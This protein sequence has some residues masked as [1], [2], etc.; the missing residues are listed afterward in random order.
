MKHT[1]LILSLFGI[2]FLSSTDTIAQL[3]TLG[4][5]IARAKN[6]STSA[7]I[8]TSLKENRNYLYESYKATLKPQLSLSGNIAD[9]S[10]DFFGVRQPDGSLIFLPRK[11]NYSNIGLSLSQQIGLTGGLLAVNSNLTRFDD[12]S[13]KE[14]QYSGNPFT[15]SLNQPLFAFNS[16]KWDRKIE[17]LKLEEAEKEYVRKVEILSLTVTKLYFDVLDAQG[18][19]TLAKKNLQNQKEILEIENQKIKFGTT[20][21][22][23]I[24]QLE[25]QLLK[26]TQAL[27]LAEVKIRTSVFNL[28][29][30]IG[31]KDLDVSRLVLPEILPKLNI[32]PKTAVENA[33]KN[34]S[35]FTTF[36][37]RQLEA[38]RDLDQAKRDRFKINL[39]T[40]F[41]YSNIG[42]TLPLLYKRPNSQRALTIGVSIPVLDWGRTK[43][44]I[45]IANSN[46]NTN[47]YTVEQE[48]IAIIS[49]VNNIVENMNLILENIEISRKTEAVTEERYTLVMDRFRYG[50]VTVTDLNIAIDERDT[51]K[52][53]YI[54]SLRRYWESY[55]EIRSLILSNLND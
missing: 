54:G 3:Q 50:K 28:Q 24:L 27:A 47:L 38:K 42:E 43:G 55:Y 23:K 25:I 19:Y 6:N 33:R 46:L 52:R 53:A 8:A 49:E 15:V 9:F 13:R 41:G 37:I 45:S 12:F 7:K 36:R 16:F 11:Q 30:F 35:E 2:M 51:A 18:D 10:S 4:E 14:M 22:D 26:S 29:S 20:T 34:R 40:S 48:E 39:T 21:K 44:K 31:D 1:L 32:T 17:P 5:V